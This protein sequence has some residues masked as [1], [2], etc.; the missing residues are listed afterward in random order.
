VENL[1]ISI[2]ASKRFAVVISLI[3]I[4][5]VLV[6]WLG[7]TMPLLAKWIVFM[8]VCSSYIF[9]ML[10]DLFKL[11]PSSWSAVSFDMEGLSVVMRGENIINGTLAKST[12]VSPY[13][14]VLCVLPDGL[15]GTIC[16]VIFPDAMEKYLYRRLCVRLKYS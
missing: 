7:I 6:I 15:R 14:V 8:L 16:R 11:L 13:V 10:R 1:R 4:A 9:H 12:F 5:V 2:G 3:H